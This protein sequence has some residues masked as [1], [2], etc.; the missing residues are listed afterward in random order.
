MKVISRGKRS[1]ATPSRVSV[2][3]AGRGMRWQL[4][5]LREPRAECCVIAEFLEH[6][7]YKFALISSVVKPFAERLIGGAGRINSNNK[8]A[9]L[10]VMC[11]PHRCKLGL[12]D[13][14]LSCSGR[15]EPLG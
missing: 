15:D 5:Y 7:V 1:V 11:S 8:V 10:A 3:H 9:G 6:L 2:G 14:R 12:I 13:G 4:C